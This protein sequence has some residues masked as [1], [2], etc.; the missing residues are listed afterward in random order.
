MENIIYTH[1][2]IYGF[3]VDVG[4]VEKREMQNGKQRQSQYEVDF[5][6]TNGFEKYYIQSAYRLDSEE[7]KEQELK[8]LKNIDDSFKKIVIVSDDI[9]TYT[10]EDGITYM[11]LFNFLL[12]GI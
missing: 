10:D 7:K 2:R 9:A 1:L 12:N 11:G 4:V 8:S 3:L 5:I 6:A